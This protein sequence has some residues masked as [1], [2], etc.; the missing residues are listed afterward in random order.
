MN[1]PQ[2]I[3]SISSSSSQ[4]SSSNQI[5]SLSMSSS[6]S[7]NSSL[8]QNVSTASS[9]SNS[10]ER[11]N[12]NNDTNSNTA[13]IEVIASLLT[14]TNLNEVLP[15]EPS[16]IRLSK[17]QI[18]YRSKS[19]DKIKFSKQSTTSPN[20]SFQRANIYL[21]NK[22]YSYGL[23]KSN[24]SIGT[25]TKKSKYPP[26]APIYLKQFETIALTATSQN[27]FVN[28]NKFRSKSVLNLPT[29]T[30]KSQNLLGQASQDINAYHM[31]SNNE[32]KDLIKTGTYN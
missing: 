9:N 11:I 7:T 25:N 4:S 13:Q 8:R 26:R 5:R 2:V 19:L 23:S 31:L 30:Q 18:N 6:T 29:S 3:S 24:P 21:K 10:T 16:V 28:V 15:T 14:E 1:N 17:R 22:K 20:T 12:S 32:I 27:S